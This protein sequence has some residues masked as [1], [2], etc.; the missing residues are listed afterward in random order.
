M[1]SKAPARISSRETIRERVHTLPRRFR[2]DSANGLTAEWE[3]RIGQQAFAVS[4]V[5]HACYVREGP[6]TSPQTVITAEPA[7]WLAIDE[8]QLD[9]SRAFLERTV[10]VSGNLD[11]AVRMQTLF[12]PYRRA[13]KQADL[14]QVDIQADGVNLS[15]YVLGSGRAIL[16]VHGLGGSKISWLPVLSPLAER[17]R[18][19]VPDLPGHGESQKV[20]TDYSPRFYARVLR[21]LLDRLDIEQAM[22]VGNSMGGRVAIELAL[23]S[24]GRVSALGLVAPAVPGLRWRYVLGFTRV[25]PT[26][27]GAIPFPLRERWTEL[28]LKRLFANPGFLN[29]AAL[30]AASGEFIRIYRDPVARMAFFSSL[31][32]LLTE[33]PEP[34]FSSLR[35]IKQP[36]VVILGEHD[37][38]VPPKLGVRLAEHMRDADLI[39][40]PN[41]GHVPQFEATDDTLTAIMDLADSAL[42]PKRAR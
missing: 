15:C 3:L 7:T 28:I 4:I 10:T 38:L 26:E 23:R 12:K 32:H 39:V 6:S 18:L 13:R 34:F 11:L 42:P 31:R 35:R 1:S 19:L 22:V 36:A 24:P 29:D 37:R 27:F 16:L 40:L 17:Y 25:I 41:V 30:H 20:R 2:P 14:D 33:R 9:G 21:H 8:G 5:D